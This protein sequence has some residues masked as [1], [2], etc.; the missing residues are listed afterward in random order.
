MTRLCRNARCPVAD[1]R[2]FRQEV[3]DRILKLMEEGVAPWQKPWNAGMEMPRNPV[4]GKNYRGGN[5]M[6]L[7]VEAMDAGYD[8]PRWL[9]YKQAE[10]A[11]YQV[12]KG[13]KSTQVE[14]WEFPP[15]DGKAKSEDTK[16]K[17]DDKDD[18]KRRPVHRIYNVFNATQMDGVEPHKPQVRETWEVVQS[19]EDILKASGATIRHDQVDKAYFSRSKDTIHMPKKASFPSSE[20]YYGTALHELGHWTGHPSRLNRDTL[21]DIKKFGDLS[22]AREELRA[23]LTSVFLAAERGIP[24]DEKNHAAYVKSWSQALKE[25]KNEIFKAARDA[26]K[27]TDFLLALEREKN[28]NAALASVQQDGKREENSQS[29]AQ[30]ELGTATVRVQH[31]ATAT[32]GRVV[33]D[34]AKASER[35]ALS[36]SFG[37][38]K[39]LT[40][41]KL[42]DGAKVYIAQ[43]DSGKYSGKIIG[44]T[45]QHVVQQLSP[46][47]SVAH[48][49][50]QLG[51][52]APAVGSNVAVTYSNGRANIKEIAEREKSRSLGRE[53]GR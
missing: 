35:A 15:Q 50:K 23:E 44:E 45:S 8:D 1:K 12:R 3:T 11:G 53:L 49:K 32:E 43:L 9:T 51:D 36:Q 2:D 40:A 6:N 33:D 20:A 22:Y 38:S 46:T 18:D 28:L 17:S 16:A 26:S 24:H 5:A 4:T 13:E 52:S 14:F 25:D 10:K 41:S 29:V 30:Q 48:I 39:E 27:A 19:A 7:L 31:K 34:T 47:S 37:E 21:T 42:G